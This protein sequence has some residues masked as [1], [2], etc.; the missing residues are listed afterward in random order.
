MFEIF[1]LT[2]L[3][4]IFTK[5]NIIKILYKWRLK[6]ILVHFSDLFKQVFLSN[7]W[8]SLQIFVYICPRKDQRWRPMSAMVLN[9]IVL[10]N[11]TEVHGFFIV[12]TILKLNSFKFFKVFKHNR[13]GNLW[14]TGVYLFSVY[15]LSNNVWLLYIKGFRLE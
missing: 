4:T 11:R 13:V 3:M 8:K 2:L 6:K 7:I 14:Y 9:T 5:W 15:I 10:M 1:F 12:N